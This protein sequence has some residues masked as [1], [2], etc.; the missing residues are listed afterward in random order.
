ME[1]PQVRARGGE[2]TAVE[3]G[4]G[5]IEQLDQQRGGGV[6][7][8]EGLG[9]RGTGGRGRAIHEAGDQLLEAR[10]RRGRG[11]S[12]GRLAGK[13]GMAVGQR[14]LD[15]PIVVATDGANEVFDIQ[16]AIAR[17]R[18]RGT[19]PVDVT[20]LEALGGG[21]DI[22]RP[23]LQ[24]LA[25]GGAPR[26]V[27]RGRRRGARPAEAPVLF[28]GLESPEGV[29]PPELQDDQLVWHLRTLPPHTV[30]G[31]FSFTVST[32]GL[33][34]RPTL[35]SVASLEYLHTASDPQVRGR[36]QSPEVRIQPAVR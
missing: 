12:I 30:R 21:V 22:G 15:V 19:R 5:A 3:R 2:V 25:G 28:E 34:G 29:E 36:A 10:D 35:T 24:G 17:V 16:P 33:T 13:G 8:R 27:L 4:Q 7:D 18:E 1:R 6:L 20:R 11:R 9:G 26:G 32:A 23:G 31:P 14:P